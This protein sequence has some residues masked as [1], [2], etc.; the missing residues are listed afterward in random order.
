M[1]PPFPFKNS[2]YKKLRRINENPKVASIYID[3]KTIATK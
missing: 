2:T 3:T 1:C